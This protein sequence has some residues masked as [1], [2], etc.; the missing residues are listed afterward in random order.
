MTTSQ[1][2][3]LSEILNGQF[4]PASKRAYFQERLRNRIYSL[5]LEEFVHRNLTQKTLA[6]RIGKG[7]EQINRWLSSPGNWT[8][9]TISDLLLGISGSEL[10][11]SISNIADQLPSNSYG[12]VWINAGS[13]ETNISQQ[14]IPISDAQSNIIPFRTPYESVA[15]TIPQRHPYPGVQLGA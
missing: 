6:N 12:P 3:F 13:I 10:A 2:P 1:N 5:L 9:D 7:P 11:L 14:N 15:T 8:I 4:I